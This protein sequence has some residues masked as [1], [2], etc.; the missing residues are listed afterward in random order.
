MGLELGVFIPVGNNGWVISKN[1][2]QYRPTFALNKQIAL[3]A[4]QI[5]FDYVF[6]MAKW[7]GFGGEIQFWNHSLESMTLMSAL[8]PLTRD[9]RLIASIAPSLIHPAVYAKMA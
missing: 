7:R 2:P 5:G 3:L 8:A 1:S 4:E 9:V 6:S